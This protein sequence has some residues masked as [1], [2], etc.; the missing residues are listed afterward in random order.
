[1]EKL[2]TFI[3]DRV[4]RPFQVLQAPCKVPSSY[5]ECTRIHINHELA[6]T[7]LQEAATIHKSSCVPYNSK[8]QNNRSN[9]GF[10]VDTW[11]RNTTYDS[12]KIIIE[13]G[14]FKTNKEVLEKFSGI[15]SEN[16]STF[17]YTNCKRNNRNFN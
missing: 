5:I 9:Q 7:E 16:Q 6:E 4:I 11:R 13:E 14:R 10:I 2:F 17:F 12:G 1:M 8:N 15:E 3:W